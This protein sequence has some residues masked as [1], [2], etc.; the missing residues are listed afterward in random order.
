MLYSMTGFASKTITVH[1]SKE[2]SVNLSLSLKSLN[3]RFFEATCKLPY[4][5]NNLETELIK[6][7]KKELH[8]GHI[9]FVVHASAPN[10]VETEILPAMDVV[11]GYLNAIETIKEK[12]GI[13]GEITIKNILSL[14]NIFKTAE[15]NIEDTQT[16]K[17]LFDA[18]R[19]LINDVINARKKEGEALEVDIIKRM[20]TAE[21]DIIAIEKEFHAFI[22]KQK[23][24]V[25]K[26][27][28]VLENV[29]DEIA[30]SRRQAVYALLN[31]IDINEEIVR[32]K[33]HL[34][35]FKNYLNNPDIEKGKRLDFTLQ[36]LMRET[37][38]IAAKCSNSTISGHAVNIKV[39]LEKA[40]EQV[41]NVV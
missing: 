35:T 8:R 15:Q 40:R 6:L 24:I 29:T 37:N 33:N 30:E 3:S 41:Q 32:F 23:V 31:K 7:F 16:I 14:P 18:T 25:A 34:A 4:A 2:Q 20:N 22:E 39:E 38:T 26:E 5:L 9:Y 10:I 36:E 12:T 11:R 1:P 28:G 17:T 21:K 13:S 19:E 27:I